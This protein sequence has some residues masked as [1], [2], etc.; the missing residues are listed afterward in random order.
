MVQS[1]EIKLRLNMMENLQRYINRHTIDMY[2][3]HLMHLLH[4]WQ[5]TQMHLEK[6]SPHILRQIFP[7]SKVWVRH[8]YQHKECHS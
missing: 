3:K 4:P 1:V 5:Y 6:A 7:I 2:T 8:K